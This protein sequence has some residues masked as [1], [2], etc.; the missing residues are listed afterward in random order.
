MAFF[1]VSTFIFLLHGKDS[2]RLLPFTYRNFI[3]VSIKKY[4]FDIIVQICNF[5]QKKPLQFSKYSH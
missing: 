4:K 5:I 1:H 2:P 3:F